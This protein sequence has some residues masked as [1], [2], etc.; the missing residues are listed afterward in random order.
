MKHLQI[1]VD[2]KV[3]GACIDL[4]RLK[5]TLRLITPREVLLKLKKIYE[6]F[7]EEPRRCQ[8]LSQIASY[9]LFAESDL[10]KAFE[11]IVEV[12]HMNRQ[13]DDLFV[14]SDSF[15]NGNFEI[16]WRT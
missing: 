10:V 9:Y 8:T 1:C 16:T 2:Q 11:H 5:F 6:K 13:S 15:L 12:L 7:P 3:Y 4:L 14:S